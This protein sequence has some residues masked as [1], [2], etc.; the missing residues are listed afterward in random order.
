VISGTPTVAG[1]AT[2]TVQVTDSSTPTP[3]S[4]TAQ[5]EMYVYLS[6]PST[7][8]SVNWSG[9]V[10]GSGPYSQVQG[11]FNVPSLAASPTDSDTAE[12]VGIDGVTNTA[13]IQAGVNESYSASSNSFTVQ[14]WWEILPAPSTPITSLE[15]A[16]GDTVTVAIQQL[17][18]SLWS[19]NVTDNSTGHSFSTAQTYTG[20]QDTAEWILEAPT[21]NGAQTTLGDYAPAVAFTGLS[22]AGPETAADEFVMVQNGAQVATP[23]S[24]NSVGFAVAYGDVPPPAP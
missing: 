16:P 11:T 8:A 15:V 5:I 17:S 19:I 7:Y 18:G 20:P 3:R 6:I 14:P 2:F 12:W 21:A 1:A 23:S 22:A 9:Y 13:L 10:V 24:V 4:A